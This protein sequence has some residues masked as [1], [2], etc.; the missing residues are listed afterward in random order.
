MQR[1]LLMPRL[2]WA[3]RHGNK[4]DEA[5]V[6]FNNWLIPGV[7]VA[8][9]GQFQFLIS[10]F[11]LVIGPLNYWWLKR[12]KKLPMLLA[13]VPA[14]AAVVTLLLLSFGVLAD[15]LGVR[16]RARSLTMLDQT[17][18]E[19]ATWARLSYYAGINPRD[20]LA[21]PRDTVVYPIMSTWARARSW[22]GAT[23]QRTI[24]VGRRAAADAA[25]G[26]PRG[27]RRSI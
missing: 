15:G 25:A 6:E 5:N 11:V 26:S 8:P 9:V 17:A 23:P 13:T 12:R 4:P 18:G 3:M 2:A 16:V 14:A 7:G 27:R 1:S 19:A 24:D 21:L 10:L 20:G 22:R